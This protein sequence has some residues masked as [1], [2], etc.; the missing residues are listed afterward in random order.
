MRLLGVPVQK[1]VLKVLR[2]QELTELSLVLCLKWFWY[3]TTF[4]VSPCFLFS[5]CFAWG[6][7]AIGCMLKAQVES[8]IVDVDLYLKR[9]FVTLVLRLEEALNTLSSVCSFDVCLKTQI[10]PSGLSLYSFSGSI[11]PNIPEET[12]LRSRGTGLPVLCCLSLNLLPAAFSG[13]CYATTDL[14]TFTYEQLLMQTV[15]KAI[16]D[17][18]MYCFRSRLCEEKLAPLLFE[19]SLLMLGTS[20]CPDLFPALFSSISFVSRLAS[21]D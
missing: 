13:S 11:V 20:K 16:F 12:C 2:L 8:D 15:L 21:D 9:P 17:S 18:G 4:P 6:C 7:I 3:L 1:A 10:G 19:L 14:I 5:A